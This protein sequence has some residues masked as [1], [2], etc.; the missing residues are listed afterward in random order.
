MSLL[1]VE[2]KN[3]DGLSSLLID[4]VQEVTVANIYPNF[5]INNNYSKLPGKGDIIEYI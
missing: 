3:T 2:N 1:R 4:E 5:V